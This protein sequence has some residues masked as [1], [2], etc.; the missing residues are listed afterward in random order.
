MIKTNFTAIKDHIIG[1][2][3]IFFKSKNPDKLT[4]WYKSTLGF[5]VQVP[6]SED[7]TAITF[8]WKTFEGENHNTVWAPFKEDTDY[9]APSHKNFMINYIVKDIEGLILKLEQK[10]VKL[11]DHLKEYPYG[12]FASILDIEENK[13]EFWEPNMDFFK[14]KY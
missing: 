6:Y 11:I 7:D 2:G 5:S 3:G 13:I 4:D 9:F 8:K 10:G 12:K 1:I 14:D